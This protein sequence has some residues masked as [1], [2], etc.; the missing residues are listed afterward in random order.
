MVYDT[1]T[2]WKKFFCF[3]LIV[4]FRVFFFFVTHRGSWQDRGSWQ[5]LVHGSTYQG[6]PQQKQGQSGEH[7]LPSDPSYEAKPVK[8]ESIQYKKLGYC[9]CV[10]LFVCQQPN[11]T[12]HNST[13]KSF[14]LVHH[15]KKS[16]SFAVLNGATTLAEDFPMLSETFT[17]FF[18]NEISAVPL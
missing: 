2:V 12:G 10:C 13:L 15:F 5:L 17:F 16:F 18:L 4:L 1:E 11:T 6:L 8:T 14:W 9:V 7:L 3:C